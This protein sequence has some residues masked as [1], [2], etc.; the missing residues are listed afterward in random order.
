MY[1]LD[2]LRASLVILELDLNVIN[3]LKGFITEPCMKSVSGIEILS[4]TVTADK[5]SVFF[6]NIE[7][8]VKN[9]HIHSKVE[10]QVSTSMNI[11]R[12]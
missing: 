4:E 1:I 9:V 2:L 6:D 11:F 3:D 10:G 7:N 12:T 8:P 5:L